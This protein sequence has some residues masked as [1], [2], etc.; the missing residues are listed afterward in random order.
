MEK[1]EIE[2]KIAHKQELLGLEKDQNKKNEILHQISVLNLRK[3][4]ATT[5]EKLK[6]M[7]R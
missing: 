2:A 1:E 7:N 5:K 4:M 3:E 6:K